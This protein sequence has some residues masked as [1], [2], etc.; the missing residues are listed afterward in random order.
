MLSKFTNWQKSSANQNA[1]SEKGAV[2]AGVIPPRES[3]DWN[4]IFQLREMLFGETLVREAIARTPEGVFCFDVRDNVVGCSIAYGSWEPVET[5]WIKSILTPGD[6]VVD[7]GANLGW[8]T[9][10]MARHVG[11]EGRVIAFEPDPRNFELLSRNVKENDFLE[12]STLVQTAL[13]ERCGKVLLEQCLDNLGDHRIRVRAAGEFQNNLYGEDER[14]QI[15]VDAN[16]LDAELAK[17]GLADRPL[18]LIKI[19]S[20]GS[21]VSIFNGAEKALSNSEYVLTEYWPYG[22]ERAG[23]N[24]NDFCNAV[25]D[26]FSQFSRSDNKF[27]FQ[28]MSGLLADLSCPAKTHCGETVY[29]FRK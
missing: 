28:P 22:L 6:T 14:Q 21:E 3:L 2:G 27:Q 17:A 12:Q 23:K 4:Q 16:T 10:V 1:E 25:K 11:R 26:H 8:Y 7:V 5:A 29:V 18:K 15:E 19:D 20:Q 24:S 9:V 13:L